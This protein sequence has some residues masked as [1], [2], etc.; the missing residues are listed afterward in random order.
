MKKRMWLTVGGRGR[1]SAK[2]V[3]GVFGEAAWAVEAKM[4]GL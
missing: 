3:R 1:V 4:A 2:L